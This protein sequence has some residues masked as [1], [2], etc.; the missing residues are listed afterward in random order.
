LEM[1]EEV[2]RR[3]RERKKAGR[4]ISLGIGY[5]DKEFGGGFLRSYSVEEPTNTTM[6]LYRV[7]LRLFETHYTGKTVRQISIALSNVAE[8]K[9][10]QLNLF[11]PRKVRQKK[12]GYT[13]DQIRRRYG[14]VSLLRAISYTKAGTARKRAAL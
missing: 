9:Y 8:D 11:E 7:C 4:T 5:S 2:A 1:C 12:L 13:V 10:V 14:G 6:D 3:A